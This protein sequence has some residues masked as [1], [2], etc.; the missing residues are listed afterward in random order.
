MKSLARKSGRV[1]AVLLCVMLLMSSISMMVFAEGD[2]RSTA[3]AV[4]SWSELQAALNQGGEITLTDGITAGSSDS[5][6]TVP[7][8]K[9]VT[10]DLNGHYISRG[11]TSPAD[12]GFVIKVNGTLTIN[13]SSSGNSGYITG[14]YSTRKNSCG[15]VWVNGGTFTLTGGAIKHNSAEG[16]AGGIRHGDGLAEPAGNGVDLVGQLKPERFKIYLVRLAPD[17]ER[18]DKRPVRVEY[19]ASDH[20]FLRL[21][22]SL[23]FMQR[24]FFT[25][26]L[27]F[28]RVLVYN[29]MMLSVTWI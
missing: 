24:L 28:L 12:N 5:N 15:G 6:L 18:V 9:T 20:I 29:H 16:I 8:N 4:A 21:Q 26:I 10:L 13:D 14:G 19:R 1:L 17:A 27:L 3:Q 25:F 7:K 11:L 22:K 23:Y 2:T